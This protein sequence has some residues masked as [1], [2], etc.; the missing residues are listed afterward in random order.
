MQFSGGN[1][2]FDFVEPYGVGGVNYGAQWSGTM[3]PNDWHAVTD[4]GFPSAA[5]PEHIFSVPTG[6]NAQIFLRLTVT[7]Q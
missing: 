2:F 4:S 5:P 3:Q 7:V 1:L 6:T